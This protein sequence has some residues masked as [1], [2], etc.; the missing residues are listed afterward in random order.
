MVGSQTGIRPVSITDMTSQGNAG[1][2]LD[3]SATRGQM[4]DFI[5]EDPIHEMRE[6]IEDED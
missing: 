1:L 4:E 2:T 6:G 5:E 3:M